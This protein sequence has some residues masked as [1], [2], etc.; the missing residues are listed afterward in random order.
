MGD[1]KAPSWQDGNAWAEPP[2]LEGFPLHS[3]PYEAIERSLVWVPA[4]VYG[5]P[6]FALLTPDGSVAATLVLRGS[7]YEWET[8]WDSDTCYCVGK[9]LEEIQQSLLEKWLYYNA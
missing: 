3:E 8:T 4:E 5:D 9:D 1:F 6:G 7:E 2:D